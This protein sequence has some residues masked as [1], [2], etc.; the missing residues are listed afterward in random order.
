MNNSDLMRYV[1][2]CGSVLL[3]SM[4]HL[5]CGAHKDSALQK[6]NVARPNIILMMADDLGYGDTQYN[7]HPDIKTPNLDTMARSGIR[8]D[9]FY[10]AAPVCSPTRAS[11]LTGRHPSRM[12]IFW[13]NEGHLKSEEITLA[14][15]V[16]TVGYTT[17]HFGKWHLGTLTKTEKDSNRGG[18]E[19]A[20]HFSPPWENGFDVSFS[21]EAKTATWDPLLEPVVKP[22]ESKTTLFMGEPYNVWWD[23]IKEGEA[24]LPL[25]TAYWSNGVK[26][27]APLR[28]DDSRIIMD[29]AL[30]F[31]RN[32][33][34]SRRP[35]LAVIWFH[36]PHRPLVAG[37]EY[38]RPYAGNDRYAQHYY[39]TI[40]AM[41]EQIGRLRSELKR[42]NASNN[43]ILWFT[44]DN[45]PDGKLLEDPG[46]AGPL[47][48]R[49]RDLEEGGIRVPAILEWPKE[50]RTARVSNMPCV[51]SDFFPTILD[52][53]NLENTASVRPL[54]GI[55][56]VPLITGSMTNRPRPIAFDSRDA[57]PASAELPTRNRIALI[58]NK[59]KLLRNGDAAD[60]ELYDVTSDPGERNNLAAQ[61]TET[62]AKMRAA[63]Q[64]WQASC[65]NSRA[66][67]D[68]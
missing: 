60:W 29:Q 15:A 24:T 8:F 5:G 26:V 34:T 50:I 65:E 22:K 14:E 28:G 12:G 17:G 56:L 43:T 66:G 9:R 62:V 7:G 13:A 46:L 21:T 25:G 45:G 27:T 1:I 40:S 63:L 59:Y 53:L 6:E 57:R 58:D 36:S 30:E 39:G 20:E 18:P 68:Y 54:D 42:L 48:G 61:K 49:K 3:L 52:I 4:V 37:D 35:F 55:S 2:S 41:D 32:A 10:A 44:S 67:N 11:C 33:T 38:T 51:T 16:K 19:N 47:R 64:A 23:P 31:I